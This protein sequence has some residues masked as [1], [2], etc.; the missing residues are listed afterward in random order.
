[1]GAEQAVNIIF[2]NEKDKAAKTKEYREKFL[3]PYEAAK[4]GKV[5]I[6]S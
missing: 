5:D 6:V 2:R 4:H 1:M 3:N